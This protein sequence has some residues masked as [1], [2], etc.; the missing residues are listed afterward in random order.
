MS[1]S[2]VSLR[3]VS[4]SIALA[5]CAPAAHANWPSWRGPTSDGIVKTGNPPTTWSETENIKWKVAIP[6]QSDSTPIVW[7]DRIYITTSVPVTPFTPEQAKSKKAPL[8]PYRFILMCLD[9]NTGKTLWEKTATE[10]TPHEGHHPDTTFASFSP[11]TDGE[12][13]YVNFGSR[14]AYAFDMDGE[15]LWSHAGTPQKISGEFGEASSPVIAGDSIVIVADQEGDSRI[16]ALSKSS[17]ELLWEKTREE[18]STWSTPLVLTHEGRTEVVVSGTTA[19]RSYDPATGDIYWTCSGL[20]D[21][22]IPMPVV[23]FGNIYCATNFRGA[24]L[25]AIRLGGSGDLTD[26]DSVVWRLDRATPYVNSPLIYGENI[27]MIEGTRPMLSAYSAKTGEPIYEKTRVKGLKAIYA[28]PIGVADHIYLVDRQGATI[29][30]KKGD[31]LDI[32]ATNQLDEGCDASPIVIGDELYL[33]GT[34]H[35]YCIAE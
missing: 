19:I 17:G 3:L 18:Q 31:T 14:G 34:D 24:A 35:L 11:V 15:L 13:V 1:I 21:G 7:G 12:R 25:L 29:V 8:V 2:K 32:V 27:Y 16:F 26:T 5:L 28:S 10:A 6:G 9:R 30:F 33:K 4:F 23:A 22:A 20:T